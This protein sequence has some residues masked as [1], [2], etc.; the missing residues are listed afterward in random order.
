MLYYGVMEP[1]IIGL[2]LTRA[3]LRAGLTQAEVAQ[4]IGTTQSAIS[5]AESGRRMPSIAF[6]DRFAR[7]VG[8]PITLTFGADPREPSREEV[9]ARAAEALG[10]H[11]FDPWRRDPTPAEARNLEADG[12]T[13][14]RF[15]RS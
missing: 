2:E 9:R 4:R 15:E 7:A 11:T 13:R 1:W 5:R 10:D 8:H 12:L 6:L 3:R 14:E